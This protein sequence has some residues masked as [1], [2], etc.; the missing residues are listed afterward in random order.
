MRINVNISAIVSNNALQR[1]ENRLS[2]SIKRLSSG[3]KLNSSADDPAG[4]AISEKMRLQIKGLDQSDNNAADG[5]SILNIAD[6]AMT[7]VQNML[8]RMKE[9]AVQAANDVNSDGER[10]AIQKEL[11]SINKEIDRIANDTEFNTQPLLNGN[12]MRRVYSNIQ[13]ATQITCTDNLVAGIYGITVTEDARQAIMLSNDRI[14]MLGVDKITKEQAGKI[15]LNGY[16]ID[17]SEGDTLDD[18]MDKLVSAANKSGAK[19]FVVDGFTGS[20]NDTAANGTEYAG[21]LPQ[22]VISGNKLV[23]MT[24][25]YGSDQSLTVTCDNKLLAN[26]LGI[27]D[28]ATEGGIVS[29]GKDAVVDI[30]KDANGNRVG[31]EDSAVIS[32]KGTVITIK[33]VNNKEFVVDIPGNTAGTQFDDS[34]K[35]ATKTG[36]GTKDVEQEVTDVGT[37]SIHIGANQDQVIKIDIP[38]IT[39][40][41]LGT[42]NINVMTGYMAQRAIETVDVAITRANDIRSKIGAFENRF[43]H[44]RNNLATSTENLTK[45]LSTVTDTDMAEEMTEYTAVTVMTQAATSILSQANER[46]S[47]V[48]QLLQ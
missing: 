5:I 24:N 48:L 18:V 16:G 35:I 29:Q 47:T 27:S 13:G 33:D 14:A 45:S 46:P 39:T 11:N 9:L 1:S 21:Y 8:V 17:I 10:E 32:S 2:D 25:E 41:A 44:T 20:T 22:T 37:M 15:T 38:P 34:G 36:G 28:A 6:G 30:T 42:D 31:F 19:A 26:L 4:C 40:Y 43:E 7:E 12:L 3:Y 23:L